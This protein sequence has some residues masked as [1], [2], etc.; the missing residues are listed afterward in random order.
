[1]ERMDRQE[2]FEMEQLFAYCCPNEQYLSINGDV[3]IL[4][5][6]PA[7]SPLVEHSGPSVALEYYKLYV[8]N[9][10]SCRQMLYRLR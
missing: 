7:T 10:R 1:M 2:S 5:P 3:A 4:R 8:G 9:P 6:T